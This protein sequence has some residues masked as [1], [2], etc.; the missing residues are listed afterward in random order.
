MTGDHIL[1]L[2]PLRTDI[3]D[4]VLEKIPGNAAGISISTIPG[5]GYYAKL[6]HLRSIRAG[7]VYLP[8]IS[9]TDRASQALLQFLSLF[10]PARSRIIIG[11]SFQMRP[12]RV[13]AALVAG[14]TEALLSVAATLRLFITWLHACRLQAVP[15][16]A[17]SDNGIESLL[18]VQT[19]APS[20]VSIGGA[21][22]H[23][24]GVIGAFLK[25]GYKVDLLS[26]ELPAS[27]PDSPSLTFRQVDYPTRTYL[28]GE[29]NHHAHNRRVIKRGRLLAGDRYGFI[30]QRSSLAGFAGVIFS[31][32][33]KRPL[34]IEFNGSELTVARL[35]G[36]PLT[37]GRL[38]SRVEEVCLRHAHLVVTV[39]TL[40][41][42]ELI[43]KGVDEKRIVCHA[44]GV[45]TDEFSPD[46]FDAVAIAEARDRIGIA[47][48]AIIVTFVGTFGPWHGA[49]V[50]ADALRTMVETNPDRV[51]QS[52]IHVLF[53][54][55]GARR[56]AVENI[57]VDRNLLPRRTFTGLVD[58]AEM[59][60]YLAASDILVSPQVG[61]ADGSGFFGSP[62]KLFEYLAS[63][64]P[65][66]ASDLDQIGAVLSGCPT[67][68]E[69]SPSAS[70]PTADQCGVLVTPGD[71][72]ELAQAIWFLAENPE[73][74]RAAGVHAR[75]I[76]ETCLTW[77][78]HVTSVITGLRRALSVEVD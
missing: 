56:A 5:P 76:A 65:V 50:M 22:T 38:A 26:A 24:R 3:L 63:G 19:N 47:S 71:P 44:N 42:D 7:T 58:P 69:L 75:R 49:E 1:T 12:V 31:R 14:F 30:Y 6:K 67:V 60:M 8:I 55:D 11:S 2:Y 25:L 68:A 77:K 57:V 43:A 16:V 72:G 70:A 28:L 52:K 53:I 61:N 45:D 18:Y 39:S 20:G 13:G 29:I 27:L 15:R 35:W 48:D 36:R 10:I 54:G 59:P 34:V 73:W 64:R 40:L 33:W 23:S 62:T 37:F 46:R 74:R 78:Q 66:I 4:R 17:A 51:E 21:A 9:E 32:L 41:R